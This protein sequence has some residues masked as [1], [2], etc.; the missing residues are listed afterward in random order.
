MAR[1]RVLSP[2][3]ARRIA[4]ATAR[5]LTR[6]QARGHPGSAQ[7]SAAAIRGK[8]KPAKVDWTLESAIK[9]MRNGASLSAAAREAHVSRE[10]LAAYAKHYA[11]AESKGGHWTF[12]DQRK[13]QVYMAATGEHNLLTL[14]VPGYD[15]SS[16]AG[17]HFTQSR[18]VLENPDLHPAFVEKWAGVSIPDVKGNVRFF[19]TD[20]NAL[21]RM[22]FGEEADWTRVYHLEMPS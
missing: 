21:F 2:K 9:E 1:T 22:H 20:L 12:D 4:S 19:E 13:R 18:A 15:P 14:K 10:R 6:P 17:L 7:Q 3:Y 8:A 5:G 11:G 16:L